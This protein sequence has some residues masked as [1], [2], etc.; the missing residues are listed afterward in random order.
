VGVSVAFL[1]PGQGAQTP[2]M[3]HQLPDQAEATRT[4][5]EASQVLG[6]DVLALDTAQALS[7]TV[8]V[9]LALFVGNWAVSK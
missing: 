6:R 7:S 8:A 4:L 5:E 3:L 2:A 9:Q 1:Y